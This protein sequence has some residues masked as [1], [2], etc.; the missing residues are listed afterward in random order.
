MSENIEKEQATENKPKFSKEEY[1]AKKRAEREAVFKMADDTAREIVSDPEKFAAFLDTQSRMDRYSTVNALLI[2]KQCP[3]A[4]RL[5]DYNDWTVDDDAHIKKGAKSISIFEPNEYTRK[6][7][8]T[9]VSYN[10]KKVFDIS[11]TDES[12]KPAPTANKDPK[13]FIKTMLDSSPIAVESRD[14]L[15]LHAAAYYDNDKQT[16]YVRR[17]TGDSVVVAQEVARELGHVQLSINSDKYSRSDMEFPAACVGY[18]LCKKY[19]VDTN[20]FPIK[21]IPEELKNA[22][23]KQI[24][25][26]LSKIRNAMAD[27]NSRI[28]DVLHKQKEARNKDYE[29]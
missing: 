11:Q 28:S 6:D 1:A 25:S 3:T 8:S 14:D 22:E 23:P 15:I 2:Y 10:V 27:V 12:K 5:K 16:L 4:T 20:S 17:D 26:E 24:R 18:M 19:A 29:R 9:G 13:A 21:N 7:G